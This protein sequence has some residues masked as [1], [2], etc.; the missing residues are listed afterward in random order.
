MLIKIKVT[1]EFLQTL[2]G[3]I[4]KKGDVIEVGVSEAMEIVAAGFGTQV[5]EVEPKGSK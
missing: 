3:K 2:A 1:E 5:E 4:V